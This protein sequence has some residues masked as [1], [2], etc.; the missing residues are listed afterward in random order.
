MN[1]LG[2]ETSPYLRQHAD[3]PVDWYPWGD[4]AFER[5][6]SENKPVLLSVGYASCHWCHVMAHESFEDETTARLMNECFVNVKVDR[7]ERPDIDSIYMEATQAMTGQGGW[8]MTVL[9]TPARKPFFAGTYFPKRAVGDMPTFTDVIQAIDQAWRERRGDI[10]VQ[11]DQLRDSI[12]ARTHIE[13]ATNAVDATLVA[14]TRDALLA[15]HDHEWG[16]FGSPPKFPQTCGLEL[17]LQLGGDESLSAVTTSLDAMASGGIYDHVGGGFSRYSV[18]AFW[19]VPHFEKMLYDQASLA[20]IFLHAYQAT[21]APCYRQVAEETIEYVLRDLRSPDGMFYSSEDAD[22]EGEEG[23]FYVWR[24][25][26][27][28]AAIPDAAIASAVKSWYGTTAAGNFEGS[29]ILHRPVRGDLLRSEMIERGRALLFD[30]RE[31]RVRPALDDKVLLEWNAM[32]IAT[33]AEAGAALQHNEWIAAAVQAADSVERVL[34]HNG[35][36]LRSVSGVPAFA[37]DYA[38]LIVAFTQLAEA[39]GRAR[40]RELAETVADAMIELFWD[41]AVGGLFT[42]GN[43]AEQLIVR[44]KDTFDGATASANSTA[45]TGLVRLAALTDRP[46]FRERAEQ[47]TSLATPQ[48]QHYPTAFSNMAIAIDFLTATTTET[49][50]AGDNAELVAL[51][52]KHYLPRNVLLHGERDSTRLWEGRTDGAYV[53]TGTACGPVAHTLEELRDQL[54]ISPDEILFSQGGGG[55]AG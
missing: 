46:D 44:N 43:N 30:A 47:I 39:T 15:A 14:H 3:N 27:T 45:A 16:G 31:S 36:R 35:R 28:D 24:L 23:R 11:A 38:W 21:G 9:L 18:D 33:L 1:R 40:W 48:M 6:A 32:F 26:E 55:E 53:C 5:A 52:Q 2:N 22:S 51:V 49:V 54:K 10:D 25:E 19:M 37:N 7:E 12:A 29:N 4:E 13:R 42:T 20:R 41:D 50:V 34:Q 17:L 8:P